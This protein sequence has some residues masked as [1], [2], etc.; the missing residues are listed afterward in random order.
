[1]L[2]SKTPVKPLHRIT[3]TSAKCPISQCSLCRFS[4]FYMIS[5]IV[6]GYLLG[7]DLS[8]MDAFCIIYDTVSSCELLL[9]Y[10][11]VVCVVLI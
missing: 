9:L 4:L 5:L 10:V 11:N 6:W 8:Q 7:F 2:T 1:M 3:Y